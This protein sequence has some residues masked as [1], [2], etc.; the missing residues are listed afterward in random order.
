MMKQMFTM[1]AVASQLDEVIEEIEDKQVLS[2]SYIG[3]EFVNNARENDTYQDQTGNLRSSIGYVVVKDGNIKKQVFEG[4]EPEGKMEGDI[5]VDE[6]ASQYAQGCILI[7]VAGME[8][9][10]AVESKGYDVI[11]N[12]IPLKNEVDNL[13]KDW[14]DIE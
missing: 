5:L 7:V 14:L 13:L 6:L 8:Y 4:D 11:T 1:A 9:A 3:E 2:L 10:A 12:H